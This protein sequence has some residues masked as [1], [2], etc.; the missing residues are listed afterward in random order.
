M[1][2]KLFLYVLFSDTQL[3]V[4]LL[5]QQNRYAALQKGRI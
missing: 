4:G 3:T 1:E 2:I 5:R